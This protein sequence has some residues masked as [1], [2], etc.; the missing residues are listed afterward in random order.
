LNQNTEA[1][2]LVALVDKMRKGI[3]LTEEDR[4]PWLF[5]LRNELAKYTSKGQWVVLACSALRPQYR[6]ILL[7][8]ADSADNVDINT[9]GSATTGSIKA[10]ETVVFAY[11]KCSVELLASRLNARFK[12]GQHFMPPSLLKS[13]LDTLEIIE[14]D[15]DI[16]TLDASW[17]PEEIVQSIIN[18][19]L[20]RL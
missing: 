20:V 19:L 1:F 16:I 9:G 18:K 13:Q 8:A 14:G 12:E 15:H 17:T 2:F 5:N 7:T 4:M 11:L 3:A 10:T 6:S